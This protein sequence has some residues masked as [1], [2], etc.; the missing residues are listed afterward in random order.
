M[1]IKTKKKLKI[2]LDIDIAMPD[3]ARKSR[4]D[5]EIKDLEMEIRSAP[6]DENNNS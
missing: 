5:N 2:C 3:D 6:E 1:M 4:T